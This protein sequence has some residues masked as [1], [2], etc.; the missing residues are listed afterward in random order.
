MLGLEILRDDSCKIKQSFRNNEIQKVWIFSS[1]FMCMFFL[2][3]R[4]P[5]WFT[6]LYKIQEAGLE[7]KQLSVLLKLFQLVDTRELMQAS[8]FPASQA[9]LEAELPK[10]SSNLREKW[11]LFPYCHKSQ[12]NPP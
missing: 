6:L 2:T 3:A 12:H 10:Q 5:G 9:E 7:M 4:S 11:G 8:W 1:V